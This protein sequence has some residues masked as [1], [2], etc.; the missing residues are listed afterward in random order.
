MSKRHGG[1]DP[2]K[3]SPVGLGTSLIVLIGGAGLVGMVLLVVNHEEPQPPSDRTSATTTSRVADTPPSL[4]PEP[5]DSPTPALAAQTCARLETNPTG[6]GVW[7][8]AAAL[9]VGPNALDV[10]QAWAAVS[11]FVELGCDEHLELVNTTIA[12]VT[13]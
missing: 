2:R 13:G 11:V 10:D 6:P 5:P 4:S 3:S 12:E 9:E 7:A 8:A 1:R